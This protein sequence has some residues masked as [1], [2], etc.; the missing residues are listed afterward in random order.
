MAEIFSGLALMQHSK[1]IKTSSIPLRT[2]KTHFLGLSL[3]L[4]AQSFVKVCSRSAM[5]WSVGLDL[6]TMSSTL[7]LTVYPMRST[8]Y[9]SMQHWY[10]APTFFRANGIVT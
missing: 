8:N 2:A 5:T 6:T 1:M 7:A 4:F 3:M 9:L 10:V